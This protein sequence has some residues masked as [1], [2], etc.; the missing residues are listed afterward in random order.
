MS[1]NQSASTQE[2]PAE[3]LRGHK[4][5]ACSSSAAGERK[6]HDD[7]KHVGTHQSVHSRT[8]NMLGTNN[9]GAT[10]HELRP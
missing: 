3:L 1:R 8:P 7:K 2:M 5:D 10:K 6:E 9:S 4:A